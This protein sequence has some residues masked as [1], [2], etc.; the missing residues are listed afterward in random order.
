MNEKEFFDMI[1]KKV[2]AKTGIL[3]KAVSVFDLPIDDDYVYRE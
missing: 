2:K 1:K 3:E